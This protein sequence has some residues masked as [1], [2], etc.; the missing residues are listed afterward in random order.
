MTISEHEARDAVA[1]L[2]QWL[3]MLVDPQLVIDVVAAHPDLVDDAAAA[4]GWRDP[5]VVDNLSDVVHAHLEKHGWPDY[6]PEARTQAEALAWWVAAVAVDEACD[7]APDGEVPLSYVGGPADGDESAL[8]WG[9]AAR[10]AGHIEELPIAGTV[11]RYRLEAAGLDWHYLYRGHHPQPIAE[12][13]FSAAV[14][15]GPRDGETTTFISGAVRDDPA[16]AARV[17]P[18]YRLVRQ[19]DDPDPRIGWR[20]E[21]IG[22]AEG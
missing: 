5:D 1:D 15:G 3:G 4:D 11:H 17:R 18:G 6:G 9:E 8:S 16:K 10:L 7:A 20:L 21:W 2:G 13:P 14:V 19:G 22:D 12:Q